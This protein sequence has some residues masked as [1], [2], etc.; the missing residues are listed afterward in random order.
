MD[1]RRPTGVTCKPMHGFAHALR[2]RRLGSLVV[3]FAS[4]ICLGEASA[5]AQA[6]T[7]GFE[8]AKALA[9]PAASASAAPPEVEHPEHAAVREDDEAT[10]SPDSPRASMSRFLD[11]T[12]AGDY[13]GAADYLDVPKERRAN[14]ADLARR[15]I[16][17]VD[18]YDWIDL[19]KISPRPTGSL[20]DGLPA[21]YEQIGTVPTNGAAPEPVRLVRQGGKSIQWVFS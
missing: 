15:L 14:A 8:T 1:A 18:R 21:I 9:K 4:V 12:R 17:V 20:D 10:E 11:L 19:D 3:F 13:A 16:A 5:R 2:L 6:L 7:G